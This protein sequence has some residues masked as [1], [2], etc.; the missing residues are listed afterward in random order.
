MSQEDTNKALFYRWFNEAWNAGEF[1]VAREI[2]APNMQVHGAGGQPVEMGPEGLID[3]ITTWR[4]AFPDGHM[5]VDG[6][7]AEG[8]MVAAL[9]TWRGHQQA[10][11]YGI[12][13]N[14]VQVVC[15]SVGIDR[16]T[17]DKVTGG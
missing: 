17:D 16:M 14:G 3:L 11:F 10:A 5:S 7:V 8:D 1:A 9:L 12:P 15:T 6:L 4:T 13:G 2:I